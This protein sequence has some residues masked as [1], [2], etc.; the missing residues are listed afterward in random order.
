MKVDDKIVEVALSYEGEKELKGN[1]GWENKAL[2]DKMVISGWQ[3]GQAW[4]SYLAE[5]VWCEAFEAIEPLLLPSIRKL[6]SANAVKTYENFWGSN[7]ITN[8]EPVKGALVIW[9][10]VRDNEP[11][12]VKESQWIRGHIGLVIDDQIGQEKFITLEGNSNSEGGRE[13]IEVARQTR[14][15]DFL[16]ENGLQLLG[17]VHP[18]LKT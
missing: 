14:G 13:G 16:K 17:F 3:H 12:Y 8:E 7:F 15:F 4:C 9:Q 2:E 11:S 1:S 10:K 5:V 6:F 18:I